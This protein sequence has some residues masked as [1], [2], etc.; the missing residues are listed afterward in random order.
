MSELDFLQVEQDV[1]QQEEKDMVGGFQVFDA[2]IYPFTIKTAYFDK[3]A[4]GANSVNILLEDEE[5][6][7][8]YTHTEYITNRAGNNFYIDKKDKKTKHVMPGFSK[9]SALSEL[10]TGAILG[11][12]VVE[13]K[14]HEIR[15][16]E[17][18]TNVPTPKQTLTEW[19][20]LKVHVGMLKILENKSV[21]TEIDGK[22]KYVPTPE[23]REVNEVDKWFNAEG[24]TLQEVKHQTEALFV[25]EWNKANKGKV[26]DKSDK[27]LVATAGAPLGAS[28][29]PLDFDA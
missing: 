11:A 18:K 13:E 9:M 27:A 23:V 16:F 19:K 4:G 25:T 2:A 26:R 1:E 21:K 29:Q 6:G 3:S 12:A 8:K 22:V 10:L 24:K 15:N 7:R 14:I 20:G 5:S 28:T 17:T